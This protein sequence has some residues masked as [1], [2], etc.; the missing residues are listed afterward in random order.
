MDAE[1]I[2]DDMR[3]CGVNGDTVGDRKEKDTGSRYH[4]CGTKAE[5]KKDGYLK[6]TESTFKSIN[7]TRSR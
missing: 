5:V 1:V 6:R 4:S 3:A 2:R 7:N